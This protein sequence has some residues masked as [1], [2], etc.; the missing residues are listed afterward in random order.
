MGK[1]SAANKSFFSLVACI[2]LSTV[3]SITSSLPGLAQPAA[4][5]KEMKLTDLS[6]KAPR[7]KPADF[8]P[9]TLL[10]MLSSG[11]DKQEVA[12][13]LRETHGTVLQTL[14]EGPMTTLVIQVEKGKL[15]QTEKKLSSDSHFSKIQRNLLGD[16][17]VFTN[18]RPND[19][20]F[21]GQWHLGALNAPTAW[22]YSSGSNTIIA[23]CDSGCQSSNPELAG[24]LYKGI[25]Y[26]SG[27]PG[28]R[29]G[30]NIDGHA[31]GSHGTCV[32]TTA[33][34]VTNNK[35]LTASPAYQSYVYPIK[36]SFPNGSG[37]STNDQNIINAL[38]Q[39]GSN[40]IR[41]CNVS[42]GYNNVS[43]SYA[44]A[45]AHPVLHEWMKWYHD[46]TNGLLFFSAGNFKQFD[47][48][49]RLPYMMMISALDTNYR[50]ADFSN[51]GNCIWFTAPGVN[52]G[53]SDRNARYNWVN[54]TSFASPLVAS[55]AAMILARKPGMS[56]KQVEQALISSCRNAAGSTWN[57]QFGYGLPDA[58]AA[59]RNF[60]R[61][62]G[63]EDEIG[64]E[65]KATTPEGPSFTVEQVTPTEVKEEAAPKLEPPASTEPTFTKANKSDDDD[66]NAEK[67]KD[68][69]PANDK[70]KG[71]K[72]KDE[73]GNDD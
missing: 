45:K 68:E 34:A 69:K 63:D 33:A 66:S 19:P 7:A 21:S 24:K 53:C 55:V 46:S 31:S 47:P 64:T 13:I 51:Y 6:S 16:A 29:P 22:D 5:P 61:G 17:M 28:N 15:D 36:I 62:I 52:V 42:Y 10:V 73:K 30:G 35:T 41:V 71:D 67:S 70:A 37:M 59:L 3:V 39:C 25:D 11:A 1:G 8:V 4:T 27:S 44:S 2:L 58:N 32:A 26:T 18:G 72:S 38:Y 12:D 23:V 14:G 50:L 43:S 20:Y 48:S 54:G 49:P 40:G 56:N 9:D 60:S 65:T 57:T